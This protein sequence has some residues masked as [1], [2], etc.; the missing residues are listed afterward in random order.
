MSV[1]CCKM[2]ILDLSIALRIFCAGGKIA[3]TEVVRLSIRLN[4]S[5]EQLFRKRALQS[6][7][8]GFAM[9]KRG[10]SI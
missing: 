9:V 1:L 7:P 2:V 6:F 5:K 8:Q 10:Y 4:S 3:E